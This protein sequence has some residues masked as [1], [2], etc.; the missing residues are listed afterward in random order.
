LKVIGVQMRRL[1]ADSERRL[2][3]CVGV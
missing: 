2:V 1:M 3:A